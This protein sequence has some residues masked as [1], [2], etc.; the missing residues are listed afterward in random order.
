MGLQIADAAALL[1]TGAADHLM[2]QLER[3]LGRARISL[4]RPR[5]ASIMPTRLSFGKWCPL[6]TSCVPMMRS[7]RPSATSASSSRK[8]STDSTR[9]LDRTRMRDRGKSSAGFLLKSL[10]ARSNRNKA[11]GGVTIRAFLQERHR[12]AAMMTDQPALEAVV[13]QPGVAIR[14]CQSEAAGT[15]ERQRCVAAAIEKQQ[16]LLAG[17]SGRVLPPLRPAVAR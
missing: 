10:N 8:R 12:E 13:D 1:A 17:D 6:A 9:S 15:A 7:K 11:V 2:Q 3:A 16:G 14:A 4:A 5:S